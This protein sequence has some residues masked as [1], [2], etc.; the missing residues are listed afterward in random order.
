MVFYNCGPLFSHLKLFSYYVYYHSFLQWIGGSLTK[1]K[2]GTHNFLT[3]LQ[4]KFWLCPGSRKI[5]A[6]PLRRVHASPK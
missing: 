5:L 4:S 2:E 6:P 1:N 3:V